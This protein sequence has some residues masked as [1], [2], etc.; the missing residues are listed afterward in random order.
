M[1]TRTR[2]WLCMFSLFMSSMWLSETG[3]AGCMLADSRDTAKDGGEPLSWPL[4]VPL[5]AGEVRCGP[6]TRESETI[7]GLGAYGQV[8]R[9]FRCYNNRI[10]F[11]LQDDSRP[12]GLSNYGGNLIDVDLVRESETAPG[13]DT[14]REFT[15]GF[16]VNEVKVTSIEVLDN[17]AGGNVGVIR[18]TGDPAPMSM[19]PQASY[20]RQEL[21][22]RVVTD[23]ILYPNAN[24]IE[25]KTTLINQTDDYIR[26]V[27]YAD[28]LVMGNAAQL[29]TPEFGFETPREFSELSFFSVGRGEKTSYAFVCSDHNITSPIVQSGIAAPICRDDALIGIEASYSRYLV[30]GDGSLESVNATAYQLRGLPTGR[31]FGTL[32]GEPRQGVWVSALASDDGAG[33]AERVVNQAKTDALGNYELHLPPGEYR[34]VAHL[35][36]LGRSDE[37]SLVVTAESDERAD[38]VLGAQGKLLVQ[39]TFLAR[40]GRETQRLPAKLTVFPLGNTQRPLAVLGDFATGGAVTYEVNADGRFEV[41]LPP[42][43]YRAYVSRGF[44]FSRF[45][46]ELEISAGQET[47]VAATLRHEMDTSGLL[48]AEFH[49]HSLGSVDANVPVP[50]KVMENA[51]EGVE[52]AVSTDHDN[53]VDFRSIAAQMGLD[54]HL[55]AFAGNEISYQSIGHFNAFPWEIDP[56][57]PYRDVGSRLWIG[58]TLPELFAAVRAQGN[59]AMV[60][61]NH[62]RSNIAGAFLSMR[63]DP[64]NATRIPRDPPTLPMLPANVYEEWSS[65]FEAVEVNGDLGAPELFT[66]AG[67]VE[68][69][70]RAAVDAGSVPVWADYMA[71]LGAGM[72]VVATGN[73]DSHKKNGGVGYPRN[74]LR[75]EVQGPAQADEEDVKAAVRGQRVSVGSGCL[76]ELWV[77]DR[78]PMGMDEAISI[79]ELASL[80]IQ[81]QSPSHV[82][83]QRLELYVNGKI[84][85]L[86]EDNGKVQL[87]PGGQLSLPL[88]SVASNLSP[89][90]ASLENW[91]PADDSVLLVAARGG[92][93]LSPTGG[94]QPF[95]YSAPL[96]VDTGAAGWHGW[97]EETQE[98]LPPN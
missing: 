60:Q 5:A 42:G 84:Q 18:V 13:F 28:F 25:I 20:L 35:D 36:G 91:N 7:G 43:S 22:A 52:I 69:A 41:M 26:N 96:Y 21:P 93:G 58:K 32:S 54:E 4:D 76:I 34:L 94:G 90:R 16:G 14:F 80:E 47:T 72:R 81:L 48:S 55:L 12:V 74:F 30:V 73:S 46:T 79:D 29:H 39:T 67:S 56:A 45:E 95:C 6:V 37:V 88:P 10:R 85:P 92:Q 59:D 19:A 65:A 31:V 53:I 62:P 33:V 75:M 44:E 23:Y 78:R 8:G 40:D 63:F 98:V 27:L 66:E 71:L 3:C 2:A 49:Q 24:Y 87:D 1:G 15:V 9:S 83:V 86:R 51:A 68:L 82:Q 38:F 61:L 77:G 64:T 17:G 11:L 70:R 89:W 57:D 97:L 50:I